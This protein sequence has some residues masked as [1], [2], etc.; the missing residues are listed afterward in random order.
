MEAQLNPSLVKLGCCVFK[1]IY[2]T[3]D[4]QNNKDSYILTKYL[5]KYLSEMMD[6]FQWVS[7]WPL[8]D[9]LIRCYGCAMNFSLQTAGSK[10]K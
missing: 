10:Q 1:V 6:T 7:I 3:R 5:I 9:F 2:Y 8:I 4:L